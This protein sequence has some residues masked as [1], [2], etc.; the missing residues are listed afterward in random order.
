MTKLFGRF[1]GSSAGI[2]PVELPVD[3]TALTS[4]QRREIRE[5]YVRQ[6]EGVCSHC[7]AP[8]D[9][10]PIDAIAMAHINLALFPPGFLDHPV[11]LHHDHRTGL[12]I[13]AV[14]SRCNAWLWQFR[15]E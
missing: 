5:Q 12:T 7:E 14:H 11:H 9:L 15:G 10:A 4:R 1:A 8:L 6:Q 13:G 3:Y 2:E